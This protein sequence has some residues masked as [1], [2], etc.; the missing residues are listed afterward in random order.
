MQR[1]TQ[2]APYE[3][4]IG[5]NKC[6]RMKTKLDASSVS[7]KKPGDQ[8]F[9]NNELNALLFQPA[10]D[11]WETLLELPETDDSHDTTASR[12]ETTQ[13]IS[14]HSRHS[15]HRAAELTSSRCRETSCSI[16]RHPF[17]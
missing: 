15:V 6:A 5:D 13:S 2:G 4:G 11:E 10:S 9:K 3:G 7:E 1:S 14:G 17:N 8:S 12:S 16:M